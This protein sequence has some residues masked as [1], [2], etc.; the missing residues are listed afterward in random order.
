MGVGGSTGPNFNA[1][2]LAEFFGVNKN[3]STDVTMEFLAK[4]WTFAWDRPT[5]SNSWAGM[6]TNSPAGMFVSGIWKTDADN[7]GMWKEGNNYGMGEP[8]GVV[9]TY[10][11]E[12]GQWA[13]PY[14]ISDAV[15]WTNTGTGGFTSG[16][17]GY[18]D[19]GSNTPPTVVW[20]WS[21]GL[22]DALG[23]KFQF[24][25]T[26]N[27]NQTAYHHAAL[28]RFTCNGVS[29]TFAPKGQF[30]VDATTTAGQSNARA[31]NVMYPTI[32]DISDLTTL[33]NTFG[34]GSS[35]SGHTLPSSYF[36]Y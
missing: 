32:Y 10:V 15:T 14:Q 6:P 1:T 9:P 34:S 23:F 26:C 2:N 11:S 28:M 33:T 8:S 5:A 7:Y 25:G 35:V 24:Y 20:R 4:G 12:S 21:N 17:D 22:Q 27:A 18:A 16:Y 29:G 13:T 3:N 31:G 30:R 36:V 19:G